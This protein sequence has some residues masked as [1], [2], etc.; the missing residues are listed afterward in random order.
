MS[1]FNDFLHNLQFQDLPDEVVYFARR[2]LLDLIGVGVGGSTT[3]LSGIIR[4][5]A[6]S[7]FGAGAGCAS[8]MFDGRPV[9]PAGAALANGMTID[10]LD[11]HDGF[12]P[13][14]GHVGCSVF[15]ALL[16]LCEAEHKPDGGGFLAALVAGYEIGGRAGIALHD[17]VSDYHTSGAWG[18]LACAALGSKVL[19]LDEEQTRHAIGI[20]EYHGPRSQMMRVIDHPT[21]LKD[22]SGI[23]AMTGITAA[24]LA[25]EGFTGAPAITVEEPT[26]RNIWGD[27]GSRWTITEQY[28]KAYP[29]C[30]WAQPALEAAMSLVE[31]HRIASADIER[32][33]VFTF[34]EGCRLAMRAPQDTEQAQ[35][36]LPFPVAAAIVKGRLGPKEIQGEALRDSEILRL[37]ESMVLNEVD[38]YNSVFPEQRYAHAALVLKDGT[39]HQSERHAARGDPE[40]HLSDAEIREKFHQFADPVIGSERAS[41]IEGI[42]DRLGRAA[43][44][45]DL[46]PLLS[47]PV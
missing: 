7:Q 2:C 12:K 5:I 8:L 44:L 13:T 32:I 45:G 24:Y 35:Y 28:F 30:R 17:T 14:K 20:A 11:A 29:V 6:V 25:R 10:S 36:S 15:P 19:K 46:L 42:V 47:E 16:A 40:D 34:H 9:S 39:R 3:E 37:S 21:M 23:G 31:Q 22:G 38:E 43:D 4:K 27:L 18:A 41:A 33:E 26:V 1:Q